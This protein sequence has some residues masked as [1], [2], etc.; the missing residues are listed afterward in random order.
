MDG[1]IRRA[2]ADQGSGPP[3]TSSFKIKYANLDKNDRVCH[4]LLRRCAGESAG[5]P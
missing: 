2:E 5:A 1:R 3:F 4:D